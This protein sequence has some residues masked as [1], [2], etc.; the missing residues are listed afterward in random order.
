M[1]SKP[2]KLLAWLLAIASLAF[3]VVNIVF[4]MSGRFDQGP[5]ADYS[6][7]ISIVNWFVV[8]VKAMGSAVALASVATRPWFSPRTVNIMIWGAAG[9]LGVYSL[10]SMGQAIGMTFGLGGSPELIDV[11]G[12]VYVLL[13]LLAAAGF[14]VLALSHTRRARLGPG[15]AILGSVGGVLL[16]GIILLFLPMVLTA[17][18]IMPSSRG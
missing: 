15:P 9:V 13:F 5:F 11:A 18:G 14:A 17:F 12:I 10:G 1:A 2:L 4:E 8:L 7:G 16:L 6:S 3:A